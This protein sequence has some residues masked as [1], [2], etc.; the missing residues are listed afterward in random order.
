MKYLLLG[1]LAYVAWRWYAAQKPGDGEPAA[2][3]SPPPAAGSEKMVSCAHC[4]IHLPQS[5][6]IGGAGALHFCSNEHRQHYTD[7]HP[8]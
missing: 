8:S 6:A 2:Q 5:E 1:L 7:R 4:S 3:A